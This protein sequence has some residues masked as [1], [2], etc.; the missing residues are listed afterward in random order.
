[1][2]KAV[3]LNAHR[4]NVPPGNWLATNSVAPPLPPDHPASAALLV[5]HFPLTIR[6]IVLPAVFRF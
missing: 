5:R 4:K 3:A 6:H 1:M 2:K